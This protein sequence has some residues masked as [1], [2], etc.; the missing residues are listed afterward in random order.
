RRAVIARPAH[1][2]S[3]S[4]LRTARLLSGGTRGRPLRRRGCGRAHGQGVDLRACL[5]L[6]VRR[7]PLDRPQP[8]GLVPAAAY[9]TALGADAPPPIP[10][11]APQRLTAPRRR[12]GGAQPRREG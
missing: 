12:M 4:T 8:R 1:P 6:A 2:A 7:P 11:R 10:A 9:P 5:G 3:R